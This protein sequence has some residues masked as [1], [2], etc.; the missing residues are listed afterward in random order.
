MADATIKSPGGQ[1]GVGRNKKTDS[2]DEL[3]IAQEAPK[4]QAPVRD[5]GAVRTLAKPLIALARK[6]PVPKVFAEGG[7]ISLDLYSDSGI[8]RWIAAGT[9]GLLR[10]TS[11]H[12]WLVYNGAIG[13]FQTDHAEAVLY[14][15]M[16][17]YEV[18]LGGHIL[19][20]AGTAQDK[21]YREYRLFRNQPRKKSVIEAMTYEPE[22]TML[23]EQFDADDGVINCA[24]VAVSTDG[25]TRPSTPADLF[26]MS[27]ATKPESGEPVEFMKF[28]RWATC[29][30]QELLDWIFTACGVA[31]YGHATGLIINPYG[32]GANGKG[33][34][35]R[36]LYKVIGSHAGGYSVTLPRNLVIKEPG[37]Q[38]RFDKEGLPGKRA[39]ILF[40]LSVDEGKLNIGELK[41]IAG[42]GDMV[43]VEPKGKKVYSCRLK[44]KIFLASNDKIPIDS[45][46]ESEKRRFRLVPFNAHIDDKDETL[47][48]RFIPEY[49]KILN[50]FIEYAV[51]YYA[52]G[53]KMPP[54]KAIDVAT[55]QYFDQQDIIGQ[56]IKDICTVNTAAMFPKTELYH[57][58]E[59]YCLNEHGIKKP[60]KAKT[61]AGAMEKLGYWESRQRYNGKITRVFMGITLAVVDNVDMNSQ[62]PSHSY[63]NSSRRDQLEF[64]ESLSTLSTTTFSATTQNEESEDEP[65][66]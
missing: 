17:E 8:S 7:Q 6:N 63:K 16:Q 26:T 5:L 2:R 50:L 1:A 11:S 57:H 47:E 23:P 51:K 10:H 41:S 15:L 61:F 66:F 42:D 18:L 55:Q 22:I 56:F 9:G 44:C 40:D 58:F 59:N 27:A 39:A 45:F 54:C 46:D 12:G 34:L 36:T 62:N 3:N 30:N 49:G 32:N 60:I 64:D 13:A 31:L 35:L 53:R 21:A 4:S 14:Q 28:A 52:N 43:T 29:N 20:V 25:S 65:P 37:T 19:L 24:G 33:T 38:S 48:A